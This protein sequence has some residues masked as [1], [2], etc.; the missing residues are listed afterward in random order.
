MQA[1]RSPGQGA[2]TLLRSSRQ[3]GGQSV[4]P[5]ITGGQLPGSPAEVAAC[6]QVCIPPLPA[7]VCKVNLPDFGEQISPSELED[8]G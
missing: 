8:R 6:P 1:H 7:S 4:K 5:R 2:A 3:R